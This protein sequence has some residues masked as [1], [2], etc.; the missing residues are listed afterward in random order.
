MAFTAMRVKIALVGQVAN[1][2][3]KE[4]VSNLF[5]KQLAIF[6]SDTKAQK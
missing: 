4:Q 5:Y 1:L 6:R 2:S 3:L